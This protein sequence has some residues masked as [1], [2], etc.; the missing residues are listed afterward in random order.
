MPGGGE[1]TYRYLSITSRSSQISR[2]SRDQTGSIFH[3]VVWGR[4]GS[5]VGRLLSTG[6]GFRLSLFS[7]WRVIRPDGRPTLLRSGL[8]ATHTWATARIR[9]FGVKVNNMPT[10]EC[11]LASQVVTG[12]TSSSPLAACGFNEP[13]VGRR[14]FLVSTAARYR[15]SDSTSAGSATVSAI[16]WRTSSR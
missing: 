14:Y 11:A 7:E 13:T 5:V 4:A 8:L 16:S 10:A 2:R 6:I 12:Q 15:S 1:A 9:P 3:E